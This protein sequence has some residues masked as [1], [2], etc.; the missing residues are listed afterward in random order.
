LESEEHN[1]SKPFDFIILLIKHG[2]KQ[3]PNSKIID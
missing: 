2:R 3:L 1:Q